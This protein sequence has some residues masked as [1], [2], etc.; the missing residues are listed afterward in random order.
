MRISLQKKTYVKFYY[1]QLKDRTYNKKNFK[2]MKL[3]KNQ[4]TLVF[5]ISFNIPLYAI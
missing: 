2:K 3:R 1:V 5:L 4:Y